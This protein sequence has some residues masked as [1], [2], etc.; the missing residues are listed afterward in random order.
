M[1]YLSIPSSE[2]EIFL[3]LVLQTSV[4]LHSCESEILLLI[5]EILH[6]L[7]CVKIWK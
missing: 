1:A 3:G 4:F 2:S 5:E 6:H 7:G